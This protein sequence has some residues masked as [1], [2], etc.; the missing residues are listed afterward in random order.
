MA[1]AGKPWATVIASAVCALVA[2]GALATAASLRDQDGPPSTPETSKPRPTTA[3]VGVDGCAKDPCTVLAQVAVAGTTVQLVADA[4]NTSGRLRIGGGGASEVIEATITSMGAVLGPDSLQCVPS[5]LTACLLRGPFADGVVGQVVV[6]RSAKW[7]ELGQPFQ[8]DAG[9][10][11]LSE[12]TPDVGAEILV[13]QHMCK[14]G[15][16]TDCSKTPVF[17]RVYNLRSQDLGCTRTYNRLESLPKWPAVT[18]TK[19]DLSPCA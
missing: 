7:S 4:G 12:V 8:S 15:T 9:Y 16:D 5:S 6:G 10:L 1:S 2:A 19:K 17:V 14:R 3:G 11:A 13:A 18:L